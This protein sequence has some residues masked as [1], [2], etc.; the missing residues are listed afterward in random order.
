M[1]TCS[2]NVIVQLKK[3]ERDWEEPKKNIFWGGGHT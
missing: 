1:P 3:I 2:E